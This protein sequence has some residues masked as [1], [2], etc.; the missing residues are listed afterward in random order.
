MDILALRLIVK[1]VRNVGD[2]R[3]RGAWALMDAR[4]CHSDW[5]RRVANRH[6]HVGVVRTDIVS[7]NQRLE[8]IKVSQLPVQNAQAADG[9]QVMPD[10][11]VHIVLLETHHQRLHVLHCLLEHRGLQLAFRSPLDCLIS[12]V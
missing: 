12:R 6:F 9:D 2:V 1:Y 11:E 4:A 7:E 8:C 10:V 3:L 5:P